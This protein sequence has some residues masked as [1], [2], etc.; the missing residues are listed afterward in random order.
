MTER[1]PFPQWMTAVSEAMMAV[2][3]RMVMC[4][5]YAPPLPPLGQTTYAL[6]ADIEPSVAAVLILRDALSQFR[7]MGV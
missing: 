5:F 4:G 3:D 2:R 7:P 6:Y 1:L